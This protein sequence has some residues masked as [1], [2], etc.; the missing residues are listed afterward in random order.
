MSEQ[1]TSFDYSSTFIVGNERYVPSTAEV[2][3]SLQ[4]LL[5][6]A[7]KRGGVRTEK[8]H[9]S[10]VGREVANKI[11]DSI[12]ERKVNLV[13]TRSIIDNLYESMKSSDYWESDKN[14]DIVRIFQSLRGKYQF[15][16]AR[17]TAGLSPS[18]K[19]L[20]LISASERAK[21]WRVDNH[22]DRID[23]VKIDEEY[24]RLSQKAK[25]LTVQ[26]DAMNSKLVGEVQESSIPEGTP[27]EDG[28]IIDHVDQTDEPK[29]EP[30]MRR[31]LGAVGQ[32]LKEK[33]GRL[34]IMVS[35][36][37]LCLGLSGSD[38]VANTTLIESVPTSGKGM[39]PTSQV[40]EGPKDRATAVLPDQGG[41]EMQFP[42]Q[43]VDISSSSEDKPSEKRN[44]AES[45]SDETGIDGNFTDMDQPNARQSPLTEVRDDMAAGNDRITDILSRLLIGYFPNE[46]RLDLSESFVPQDLIEIPTNLVN[47]VFRGG[48]EKHLIS[49]RA[50]PYFV[51][52]IEECQKKG[53]NNIFIGD[54]YRSYDSQRKVHESNPKGS[55]QAG[56]SQHQSGLAFDMYLLNPDGTLGPINQDIIDIASR[57][58]IVH[59]LSWDTPHFLVIDAIEDGLI[60]SL[61]QTNDPNAIS[62]EL[63]MAQ[64]NLSHNT[65][66]ANRDVALREVDGIVHATPLAIKQYQRDTSRN[67]AE[68]TRTQG[69]QYGVNRIS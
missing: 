15:L 24:D 19:P 41:W 1:I 43:D 59:P 17:S 46:G 44:P 25:E 2:T 57:H 54:T 14:G 52:F 55:A 67:Q 65:I 18:E 30:L 36:G 10:K 13:D 49:E 7:L 6:G 51:S 33:K 66:T 20:T 42:I 38:R 23:P 39:Q 16:L 64:L 22:K 40:V 68:V 60:D 62:N 35:A 61:K 21:Q 63:I 58:G 26:T 11:F 32:R 48:A 45:T 8:G 4:I 47:V 3:K 29:R 5:E 56:H 37:I 50:L 12:L 34:A 31:M 53:Y 28:G 9:I 27:S 69:K